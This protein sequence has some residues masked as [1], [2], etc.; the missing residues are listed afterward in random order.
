MQYEKTEEPNLN[1]KKG[2]KL[3]EAI[4]YHHLWREISLEL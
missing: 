1:M 3:F 2:L 4:L